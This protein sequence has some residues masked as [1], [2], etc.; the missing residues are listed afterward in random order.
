M[1]WSVASA[2]ASR[3]VGLLGGIFSFA[4]SEGM[5]AD[6]SVGGVK[7]YADKKGER[8]L[9]PE[10]MATLGAALSAAEVEGDNGTAIAAIRLLI[11]TGCRKSEILTLQWD[12]IDFDR[13]FLRLPDSKTGEKIVPLGAPALELLTSLPRIE[14]NLFVMPGEKEGRHLVGIPK[15]WERIRK[16][17]KLDGVRLHDLRH[18]FASVGAGA[19][20]GL[21]IVG[22]LLGHRDPKTTARYAHIAD[23]PAKAAADR[24]SGTIAAALDGKVG[25]VVSLKERE[26]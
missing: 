23:D 10:E 9:S 26:A 20:M 21:P 12:Y 16:R 14:G 8:H 5:R 3:T 22:K 25:K 13:A 2:A 1:A 18:S 11:L 15:V 7:R 17:A 19:G 6:N 24:I 4:V